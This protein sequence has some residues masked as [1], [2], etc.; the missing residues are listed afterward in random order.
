[1]TPYDEA[2]SKAIAKKDAAAER[3]RLERERREGPHLSF[4][5]T[6]RV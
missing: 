3:K 1:M 5:R 4:T 2:T 6:P